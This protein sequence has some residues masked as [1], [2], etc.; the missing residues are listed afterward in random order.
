MQTWVLGRCMPGTSAPLQDIP[1]TIF[2]LLP[3]G[4][5][6]VETIRATVGSWLR[7][8]GRDARDVRPRP[9]LDSL[10]PH[11]FSLFLLL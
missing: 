4:E 8:W 10:R 2:E 5:R 6:V 11:L 1:N 3:C 7:V 9:G